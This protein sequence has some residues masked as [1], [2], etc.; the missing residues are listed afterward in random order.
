[1]RIISGNRTQKVFLPFPRLIPWAPKVFFFCVRSG[2]LRN[3]DAK[4]CLSFLTVAVSFDHHRA[5]K[6]MVPCALWGYKPQDT[7]R[8]SV[9]PKMFL[10]FPPRLIPYLSTTTEGNQSGVSLCPL[11]TTSE[12]KTQRKVCFCP[13]LRL[14]PYDHQRAVKL[15]PCALWRQRQKTRLREKCVFA[16]S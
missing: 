15:C 9:T 13:F 7:G 6:T 10:P 11:A 3:Q 12:N 1:M 16:L 2:D 5:V 8:N 4:V 14:I